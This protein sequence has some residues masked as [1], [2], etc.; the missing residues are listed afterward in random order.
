MIVDFVAASRMDI[1]SSDEDDEIV[2]AR[3]PAGS[4]SAPLAA[5]K[6]FVEQATANVR[7]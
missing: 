2:P 5:V 3:R 1:S 6:A 7:A 4:P